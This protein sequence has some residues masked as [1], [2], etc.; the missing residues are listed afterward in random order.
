MLRIHL[1]RFL[2][3][4]S[5]PLKIIPFNLPDIG[6]GIA[7]VEVL[8]WHVKPGDRVSQFDKLLEV[9]SDKATV[10]ITSRYDGAAARLR[11]ARNQREGAAFFFAR[12]FSRL[13]HSCLLS[14]S[15]SLLCRRHP[16]RFLPARRHGADRCDAARD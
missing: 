3:G 9:Q 15:L 8:A 6:E 7:E 10:D 1:R 4:S 16:P 12:L 2:H 11:P 14:L 13:L 5:A